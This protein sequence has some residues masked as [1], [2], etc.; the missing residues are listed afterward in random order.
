MLPFPCHICHTWTP[1]LQQEHRHT[2]AHP[3]PGPGTN[4][5]VAAAKESFFIDGSQARLTAHLYFSA[6]TLATADMNLS[7]A[8]CASGV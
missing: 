2:P 4:R 8:E 6:S 7:T 1:P 3:S 5:R